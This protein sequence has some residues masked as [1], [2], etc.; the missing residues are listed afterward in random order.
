MIF[1]ITLSVLGFFQSLGSDLR[2]GLNWLYNSTFGA[3][4][5][6]VT[7]GIE[8]AALTQIEVWFLQAIN[9]VLAVFGS[10][11][12]YVEDLFIDMG[13]LELTIAG[14]IGPFGPIV[15]IWVLIAVLVAIFLS[16]R[17]V[18]NLI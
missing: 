5:T 15:A 16:V 3:A 2:N 7:S 13:N 11:L 18:I 12:G 9:S 14:S 4:Y 10:L 17:A 6:Y 1:L 8:G